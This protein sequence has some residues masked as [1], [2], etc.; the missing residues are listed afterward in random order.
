MRRALFALLF[1]VPASGFPAASLAGKRIAVARATYESSPA[2]ARRS[3][4]DSRASFTSGGAGYVGNVTIGATTFPLLLDTGSND[5]WV[6]S[7]F[8]DNVPPGEPVYSPNTGIATDY[9]F[10]INYG[11]SSRDSSTTNGAVYL[12]NVAFA[13]FNFP[14]LAV[15]AASHVGGNNLPIAAAGIL[16]LGS[17]P[18]PVQ[19]AGTFPTILGALT[20]SR[21][22]D[23]NLF[24]VALMRPNEPQSFFTF[25][26]IDNEFLNGATP[27]FTNVTIARGYW[28]F[29]SEYILV[30]GRRITRQGNT[31]VADTGT[32]MIRLDPQVLPAIYEPLKGVFNPARDEWIIPGD[33]PLSEYPKITF[34]AGVAE[35]TLP[36]E[37][38]RF[39]RL[40]DGNYLGSIQPRGENLN[41]DIFGDYWLRNTYAIHRFGTAP[42]DFQFGVVQRKPN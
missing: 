2:L 36:P 33:L 16:G 24:T 11:D 17:G 13:G 38:L 26:Y 18:F 41:A 30:N 42:K 1:I 31:A 21:I 7:I 37:D 14:K 12:D 39:G 23:E 6:Y 22:L 3:T 28:E 9:R 20:S 15:G 35:I 19:P 27:V 25:G 4:G 29:P 32:T 34:F 8:T 5:L 40:S 10:S